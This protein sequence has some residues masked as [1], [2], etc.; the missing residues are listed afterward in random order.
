RATC[1]AA[2]PDTLWLPDVP[3]WNYALPAEDL[4]PQPYQAFIRALLIDAGLNPGPNGDD[5]RKQ[6][7]FVLDA[8]G[9]GEPGTGREEDDPE[10]DP[11]E[12]ALAYRAGGVIPALQDAR[13]AAEAILATQNLSGGWVWRPEGDDEDL[14]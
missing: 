5:L 10:R 1:R 3:G 14:G 4:P 8:L 11:L 12:P 7:E 13:F 9:W 2:Y 6:A